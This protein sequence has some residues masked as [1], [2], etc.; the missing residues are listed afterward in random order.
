MDVRT[1]DGDVVPNNRSGFS[2]SYDVQGT[3][4]SHCFVGLVVRCQLDEVAVPC[5]LFPVGRPEHFQ[6]VNDVS[7]LLYLIGNHGFEVRMSTTM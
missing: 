3:I 4:V 5:G 1:Y 2:A 6:F 7:P